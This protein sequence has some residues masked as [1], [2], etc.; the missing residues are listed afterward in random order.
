MAT[1]EQMTKIY[2][3]YAQQ[4]R[5]ALLHK[6]IE[7]RDTESDSSVASDQEIKEEI[8]DEPKRKSSNFSMASIL[9]EDE[10]DNNTEDS[11]DHCVPEVAP[12]QP[13]PLPQM[14]NPYIL[15]WAPPPSQPHHHHQLVKPEPKTKRVRTI[16]TT[17]QIERLEAEFEKNQYNVG[18][19]RVRLAQ[20]L[21]L[22]ETQ[23]CCFYLPNFKREFNQN[24]CR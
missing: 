4:Q 6:L 17:V 21:N 22:S 15:Q 8:K 23:V 7:Q 2:Q 3:F 9:G 11:D 20:E 16:F 13:P 18:N 19:E 5:L 24:L 10:V 12:P 1:L 14:F